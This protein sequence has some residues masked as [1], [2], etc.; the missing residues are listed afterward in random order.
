M[1]VW[2]CL[3]E[4]HDLVRATSQ[5]SD[6]GGLGLFLALTDVEADVLPIVQPTVAPWYSMAT[7]TWPIAPI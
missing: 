3:L 6:V 7:V 1:F 4:P 5:R 2:L